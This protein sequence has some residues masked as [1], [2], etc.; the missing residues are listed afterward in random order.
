METNT[1]TK[2]IPTEKIVLWVAIAS[3]IMMFAGLTSGY[4]VRKA[5]GNWTVFALPSVFTISTILIV[6]SSLTMNMGIQAIK[7]GNSAK[8]SIMLSLTL[9]LGVGFSISQYMGWVSLVRQGVF[10]VGNP[11]GS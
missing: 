3:M 10:L 9:L 6:L 2:K 11:S 4:I 1:P 5:E 7:A 8:L